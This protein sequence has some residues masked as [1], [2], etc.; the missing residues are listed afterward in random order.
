MGLQ[1]G[2][3]KAGG[4]RSGPLGRQ[5]QPADIAAAVAFLSSDDASW[6]TGQTLNVNG[7]TPL[8]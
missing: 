2:Q 8:D 6:I 7:G 4:A 5:G 3:I 1:L